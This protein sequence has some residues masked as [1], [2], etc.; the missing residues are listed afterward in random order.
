[1]N[2]FEERFMDLRMQDDATVDEEGATRLGN[3]GADHGFDPA[4]PPVAS[5]YL[6]MRLLSTEGLRLLADEARECMRTARPYGSA[7]PAT[8]EEQS[9]AE[10]WY[11]TAKAGPL[12]AEFVCAPELLDALHCQT[13]QRWVPRRNAGFVYGYYRTPGHNMGLHRDHATCE[14]SLVTCIDDQPGEGGDLLLYPQRV[15]EPLSAVRA[16]PDVGC[17]RLRLQPGET[18]VMFGKEIPHRV[19]SIGP[20]RTRITAA[21][22][23]WRP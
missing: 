21:I 15:G 22:C 19:T 23:Y 11:D 8:D 9:L 1:V 20:G 7:L 2:S 3:V 5:N 14:L 16:T 13:G 6:V 10:S 12:L 4:T 18:L 17:V